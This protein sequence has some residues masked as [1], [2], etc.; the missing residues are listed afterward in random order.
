MLAWRPGARSSAVERGR[1][2]ETSDAG[3]GALL[4]PRLGRGRRRPAADLDTKIHLEKNLEEERQILLQQQKICRN[5]ARKYFVESNRRKKAFE[6]K[7]K[8]Q[9]EREQQIREQILQQRKEK[10]EE[11]T[12]KFQRAHIPLSQRRRAGCNRSNILRR[13][14]C[15]KSNRKFFKNQFLPWK[16]PS[17]KFRNPTYN[18]K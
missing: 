9:E 18:Q 7:R 1:G 15:F 8:E 2:P 10:F 14:L 13:Q 4:I 16:K 17:S 6:E 11:V 5:R 3:D 12:E